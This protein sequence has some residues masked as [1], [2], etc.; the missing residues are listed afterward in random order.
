[1]CWVLE[2]SVLHISQY[3][4]FCVAVGEIASC[5]K[6]SKAKNNALILQLMI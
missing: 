6:I 3:I 4:Y 2:L 5:M 1:M